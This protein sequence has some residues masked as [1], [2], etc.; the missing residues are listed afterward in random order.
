M[1]GHRK[2][3]VFLCAACDIFYIFII[4]TVGILRRLIAKKMANKNFHSK[5]FDKGTR[6]K[7]EIFRDYFRESFP[8]FVHNPYFKEIFIYDFFAGQGVDAEG[9]YGTALSILKEITQ[10][11]NAIRENG[12]QVYLVLNDK[13]EAHSLRENVKKFIVRCQQECPTDCIFEAG[14]NL[15]TEVHP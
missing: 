2:F 6:I 5:K 4:H 15:I 7:V 3:E 1:S 10:H 9:V 14:K 12:K 11:C 13:E 8:V